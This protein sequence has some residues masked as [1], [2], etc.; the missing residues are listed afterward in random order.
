[1]CLQK[2]AVRGTV[3][4]TPF[5]PPAVP[6]VTGS[7]PL[8]VGS[9]IADFKSV[10]LWPIRTILVPTNAYVTTL[11]NEK[12]RND[13]LNGISINPFLTYKA[14]GGAR[15]YVFK[16]SSPNTFQIRIRKPITAYDSLEKFKIWASVIEG[17]ALWFLPHQPTNRG[18]LRIASQGKCTPLLLDP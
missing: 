11:Q 10:N 16:S 12:A 2:A 9:M 1:M 18:A 14:T 15:K 7:S 13:R 17:S 6:P 8:I 5:G 4:T 3:S